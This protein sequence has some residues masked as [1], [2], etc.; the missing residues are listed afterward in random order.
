MIDPSLFQRTLDK[1]LKVKFFTRH[2][3]GSPDES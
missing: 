3:G 1:G 2:G